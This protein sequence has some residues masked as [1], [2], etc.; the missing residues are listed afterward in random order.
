[1][2]DLINSNVE[3]IKA[4]LLIIFLLMIFSAVFMGIKENTKDNKTKEIVEG[5]E[6]NTMTSFKIIL[7]GLGIIGTIGTIIVLVSFFKNN[8]MIL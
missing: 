3:G 6:Q 8:N 1:M 5:I 7:W 4:L 2:K